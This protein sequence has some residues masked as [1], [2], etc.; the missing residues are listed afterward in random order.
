MRALLNK[1]EENDVSVTVRTDNQAGYN[2]ALD[3]LNEKLTEQD[4]YDAVKTTRDYLRTLSRPTRVLELQRKLASETR[5]S[6]FT[7]HRELRLKSQASMF[8][9]FFR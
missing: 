2:A 4:D 9:S 8:Q 5:S 3:S 7:S 1:E 6:T